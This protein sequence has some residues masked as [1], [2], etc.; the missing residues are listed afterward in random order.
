MIP[1]HFYSVEHRKF[2]KK[3]GK[4]KGIKMTRI[5]AMISGWG[6]FIVLFLLWILPQPRFIIPIFSTLA[7][8]IP[9]INLQIPILHLV[10]SIPFI[11][12]SCW[13]GIVG[14]KDVTLKVAETHQAEKII[15]TGIYSKMRHPQYFG[16]IMAHIGFSILLSGLFSLI[17]TPL[18]IFHAY[19][20]SWKEEIELIKEFGKE[21]EEY[22]KKVPMLLPKFGK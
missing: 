22:R 17:F 20:T 18:I 8:I 5:F 1:L 16:T 12:L 9:I 19:I 2:E 15:S 21:Y 10:F 13:G 6:F 3:Y 4:E 7:I 14:V 11:V